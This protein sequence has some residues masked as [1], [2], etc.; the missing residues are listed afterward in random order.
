[1]LCSNRYVDF[2]TDEEFEECVKNVCDSFSALESEILS[3][4]ELQENGIDPFKMLFDI[5]KD[6]ISFDE[7]KA[8]ETK[9]QL[10]KTVN[11]TVGEFHQNLLGKVDGWTNL[12]TGDDS[13]LDLKKDDDTVFIELKNKFNTVNDASLRTVRNHL[14]DAIANHSNA[15]AY[16]AFIVTQNGKSKERSWTYG[17]VNNPRIKVIT[18]TKIYELITGDPGALEKVWKA[19]PDA[20]SEV[21]ELDCNM[22]DGDKTTLREWFLGA[23]KEL[24]NASVT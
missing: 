14:E 3:D 11:N 2:V 1:V 9:R 4:D 17:R 22:T 10:D 20:I 15:T 24:R 8:K 7:W 23:F 19:L 13:H 18:G 21:C 12:G 6:G 5:Q 16:W